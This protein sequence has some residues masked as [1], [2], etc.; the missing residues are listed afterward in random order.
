MMESL[1]CDFEFDS[2]DFGFEK[3]N[4]QKNLLWILH[5]DKIPPHVGFSA[6]GQFFSLKVRGKDEFL[7]IDKLIELLKLK[8]I[9]SV[10]IELNSN[11]L[12]NDLAQ[13]FAQFDRVKDLKSSCLVPIKDLFIL[14]KNVNQLKE[15][16]EFLKENKLINRVFGLNLNQTYKGIPHYTTYEIE[17]RLEK[18]KH[19][20]R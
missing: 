13:K 2:I 20:K 9:S 4:H 18:L 6:Q 7:P 19:V 14:D 15:L 3:L 1:K 5:A 11:F 8:R 17:L 16:L 12:L 10:V